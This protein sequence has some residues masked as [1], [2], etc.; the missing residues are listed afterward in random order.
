MLNLLAPFARFLAAQFSRLIAK[1]RIAVFRA[2]YHT[3]CKSPMKTT[4]F[5]HVLFCSTLLLAIAVGCRSAQS[6]RMVCN[7]RAFGAKGDGKT[8]DHNAINRAIAAAAKWAAARWWCRRAFISA[9]RFISRATFISTSRRV[10]QFW[11]H[12]RN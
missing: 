5:L 1:L 12:L 11:A 8:L 2:M 6:G 4:C 3:V 9:A 10:R 7:I